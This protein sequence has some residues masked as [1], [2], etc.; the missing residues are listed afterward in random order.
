MLVFCRKFKS[1]E[2]SCVLV[3]G[4]RREHLPEVVFPAKWRKA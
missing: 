2:F 4:D 1:L 3:I